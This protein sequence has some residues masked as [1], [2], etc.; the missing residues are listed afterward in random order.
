[1]F[2]QRIEYLKQSFSD[3]KQ[4]FIWSQNIFNGGIKFEVFIYEIFN[5]MINIWLSVKKSNFENIDEDCGF[6]TEKLN[7]LL[8]E[9]MLS[10]TTQQNRH[11]DLTD[12]NQ[13]VVDFSINSTEEKN[14][15]KNKNKINC[16]YP[17]SREWLNK[18]S[19]FVYSIG[20]WIPIV[21]ESIDLSL[22]LSGIFLND[23]IMRY[24]KKIFIN[25]II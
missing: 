4:N 6:I 24:F 22:D 18:I 19:Y 8:D 11:V 25:L 21:M 23:S 2:L 1:M 3:L 15:P 17:L 9:L 16:K 5:D 14:T 7:R 13:K 20:T 12:L 10:N